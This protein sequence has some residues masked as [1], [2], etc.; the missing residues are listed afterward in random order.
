[1]LY[2]FLAV[3]F[4]LR[5]SFYLVYGPESTFL[6]MPGGPRKPRFYERSADAGTP[7]GIVVSKST[8]RPF[9]FSGRDIWLNLLARTRELSTFPH[10]LYLHSSP[11][12]T[13]DGLKTYFL[14]YNVFCL[15]TASLL[16][17]RLHGIIGLLTG[18]WPPSSPR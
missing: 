12:T 2:S 11:Y 1:M 6:W 5:V 7:G 18:P 13:S 16:L 14:I 15:S 8:S 3:S 10:L 17:L 4:V 9:I